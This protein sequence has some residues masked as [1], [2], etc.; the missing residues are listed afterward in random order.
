M[1]IL[2]PEERAELMPAMRRLDSQRAQRAHE[3]ARRAGERP[4]VSQFTYE[5]NQAAA[6]AGQ[7]EARA[8]LAVALS[9]S[10]TPAA[11]IAAAQAAVAAL[12]AH[13]AEYTKQ[14]RN[15]FRRKSAAA[16]S[17]VARSIRDALAAGKEGHQAPVGTN[18]KYVQESD[19]EDLVPDGWGKTFPLEVKRLAM[20]ADV[21]PMAIPLLCLLT[22]CSEAKPTTGGRRTGAGF[23]V[24]I[25]WMARK[26]GCSATWVKHLFNR[27]DPF[28]AHRRDLAKV[29]R[30]NARRRWRGQDE[31]PEPAEPRGTPYIHRYRQLLRYGDLTLKDGRKSLAWVD[32]TGVPRTWVDV[33]GVCYV[34]DSG[35]ALMLRRREKVVQPGSRATWR[36]NGALGD[37]R[38]RLLPARWKVSARLEGA[39]LKRTGRLR[40]APAP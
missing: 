10:S 29:R 15:P 22:W 21:P 4:E 24:S 11:R 23:Q 25:A 36:P 34:T 39:E 32:R 19:L 14:P 26:L 16:L 9:A 1:S 37:L 13:L 8:Q 28:A 20:R 3:A 40:A 30:K 2:T 6:A 31:L 18:S 27:L 17:D 35:R 5:R 12:P 7:T 33:R 38:H